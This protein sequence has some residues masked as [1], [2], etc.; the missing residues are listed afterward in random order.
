MCRRAHDLGP[1]PHPPPLQRLT[2]SLLAPVPLPA[3]PAAVQRCTSRATTC[4]A[5]TLG[6][7]CSTSVRAREMQGFWPLP[8]PPCHTRH[9]RV[10]GTAEVGAGVAPKPAKHTCENLWMIGSSVATASSRPSACANAPHVS[11]ASRRTESWSA[12]SRTTS[13]G[14]MAAVLAGPWH[15]GGVQWGNGVRF[16]PGDRRHAPHPPSCVRSVKRG[17]SSR[18]T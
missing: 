5:E 11:T 16:S 7:R 13:K 15:M 18:L 6:A 8:P 12:R 3:A 17:M 1:P 4:P 14:H 10:A 9:Q 2:W